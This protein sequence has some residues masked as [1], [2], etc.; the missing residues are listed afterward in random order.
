MIRKGIRLVSEDNM[1]KSSLWLF[2]LLAWVLASACLVDNPDVPDLAGPSTAARSIEIHAIPDAIVSDGFS[3]SVIEAVMHGPNG[4]RVSGATILF[5]I[6]AG[7]QFLDLGNLAPL[8]GPRPIAGGVEAGPVS[9]VTDSEGVARARYWAPFR[10][11]QENDATVTIAARESGTNTRGVLYA[12]ADIFLRAANRPSFPGTS[13]CDFIV[14]PQDIA[15]KVG[16]QIF[17]TATQLNGANNHPI[18][19]YEWDFG[20]NS[21]RRTGRDSGHVYTS[22]ET[23]TV[24]LFTTESISGNQDSCTKDL[25]VTTTG[26]APPPPATTTT[27]PACSTPTASFT[28]SGICSSGDI[29]AD[30][31]TAAFF[32]ASGSSGGTAGE[33]I[34]SYQWSFGDGG[35]STTGPVTSHPY[36][37]A[38][39]GFSV[40]V[41]LTVTNSC[42]A[43]AG[44]S[45]AFD[46]IAPPCP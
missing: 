8:N 34:T 16:E 32:D 27:V 7:G 26:G 37:P 45:S 5:E 6:V 24:T 31:A 10:T 23:Y 11:D 3:S 15:Y 1:W 9:A 22:P 20:D 14:E 13:A 36:A 41:S 19:R 33:T 29:L 17:F 43:T 2:T 12:Q 40:T 4:E 44:T 25:S 28:P 21:E 30:G 35:T 39:Q 38:L 42:G 18:A 46:L